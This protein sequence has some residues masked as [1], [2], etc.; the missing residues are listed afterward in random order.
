MNMDGAVPCVVR[1]YFFPFAPLG[2]CSEFVFCRQGFHC[3]SPLPNIRRPYG[4]GA[5][6]EGTPLGVK[7]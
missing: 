5:R 3:I 7:G 6:H 1:L 4:T 2:L